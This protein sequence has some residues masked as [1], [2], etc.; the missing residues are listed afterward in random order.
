MTTYIL[1]V[2]FKYEMCNH[3]GKS[4]YAY[5]LWQVQV[6]SR[7]T[8]ELLLLLHFKLKV[9]DLFCFYINTTLLQV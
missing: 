4:Y 2:K 3:T 9:D 7:T 5:Y 1:I 6:K 8:R